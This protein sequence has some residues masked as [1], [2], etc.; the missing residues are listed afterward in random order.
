MFE[1]A[2]PFWADAQDSG[3]RRIF[4]PVRLFISPLLVNLSLFQCF[5]GL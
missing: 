4:N 3:V 2:V 5:S 1:K